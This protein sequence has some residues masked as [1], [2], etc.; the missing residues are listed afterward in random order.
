MSSKQLDIVDDDNQLIAEYYNDLN[1]YFPPWEWEWE[2]LQSQNGYFSNYGSLEYRK[3]VIYEE[4]KLIA[5]ELKIG[6]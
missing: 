6:L 1:S 3:A 2:W 4:I 5:N